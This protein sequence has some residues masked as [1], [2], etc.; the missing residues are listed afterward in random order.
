MAVSEHEVL[1]GRLGLEFDRDVGHT[2]VIAG[3]AA[4]E[5][6]AEGSGGPLDVH[7]DGVRTGLAL[8]PDLLDLVQQVV[9][10]RD[11][12][13]WTS[14][15]PRPDTRDLLQMLPITHRYH[16]NSTLIHLHVLFFI[17]FILIYLVILIYLFKVYEF[18]S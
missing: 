10:R 4:E 1:R 8:S 12:V 9:H 17:Y 18:C 3:E 11:L 13:L 5:V 15:G 16:H 7:S 2:V 6:D 14:D